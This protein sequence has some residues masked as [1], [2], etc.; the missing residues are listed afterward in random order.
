MAIPACSMQRLVS[1]RRRFWEQALWGTG[2]HFRDKGLSWE[3]FLV[4]GLSYIA[5]GFEVFI[6]MQR[7]LLIISCLTSFFGRSFQIGSF[8]VLKISHPWLHS[9]VL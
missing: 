8:I 2:K 6:R 5:L 4:S 3:Q 9:V 1:F 7:L